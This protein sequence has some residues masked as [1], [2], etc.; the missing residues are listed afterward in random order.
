MHYHKYYALEVK[1]NTLPR[2]PTKITLPPIL[3][4]KYIEMLATNQGAVCLILYGF[5]NIT[6]LLKEAL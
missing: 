2:E 3:G 5:D 6:R 1:K 4:C